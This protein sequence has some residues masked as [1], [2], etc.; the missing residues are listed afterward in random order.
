[1]AP[2]KSPDDREIMKQLN[3]I[4]ENAKVQFE[5]LRDAVVRTSQ[6]AKTKLDASFLRRERDRLLHQLGTDYLQLIHDKQ[7]TPPSDLKS[8]IEA[9]K[10]VDSDISEQ[11]TEMSVI[12]EEGEAAA[13]KSQ[14]KRSTKRPDK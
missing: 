1:M 4:W 10:K 13:K 12:L 2:P 9:I 11:E 5:E 8:T 7:V 6:V 14:T 3:D